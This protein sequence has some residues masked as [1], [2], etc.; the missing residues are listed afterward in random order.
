MIER[1][2]SKMCFPVTKRTSRG[3]RMFSGMTFS[4]KSF[5]TRRRICNWKLIKISFKNLQAMSN[6]TFSVRLI[7]YLRSSQEFGRTLNKRINNFTTFVYRKRSLSTITIDMWGVKIKTYMVILPKSQ[8]Q[9]RVKIDRRRRRRRCFRRRRKSS[10][11]FLISR[12]TMYFRN[13]K[14]RIR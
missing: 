8:N 14:S 11:G 10:I 13:L 5:S 2:F 4:G 3:I 12:S 9:K 6:Y 1:I 7:I